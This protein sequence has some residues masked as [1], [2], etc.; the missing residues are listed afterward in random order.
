MLFHGLDEAQAGATWAPFLAWIE[1]EP[2]EYALKDKPVFVAAPARRF[3]DPAFLR[4][5]PGIVLSDDWPGAP[6]SNVF[7]ASNLSEAGQLL[8]AYQSAWLPADLLAH[9]KQNALVDALI[10]GST[11]WSMT[12]HTNKGLAGG[13]DDAQNLTRET[14]TNPAVLDAFALLICAADAPP[15]LFIARR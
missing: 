10:A 11:E 1:A 4:Q 2:D 13:S 12:L 9:G 15:A 6:A 5:L 14:A 7:W 3:W 8:H